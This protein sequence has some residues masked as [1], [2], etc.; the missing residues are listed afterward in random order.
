MNTL[1]LPQTIIRN[2]HQSGAPDLKTLIDSDTLF[3]SGD[4][5]LILHKGEQYS[6]RRTRNGKLI[7]N[8]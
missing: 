6:L 8:K 3:K 7:L 4:V 5:V 2:L 1:S